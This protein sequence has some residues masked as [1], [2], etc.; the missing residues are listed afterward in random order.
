[1]QLEVMRKKLQRDNDLEK[2]KN[3]LADIRER[4]WH[5]DYSIKTLREVVSTTS[6]T[7]ADIGTDEEDIFGFERE[8]CRDTARRFLDKGK[9]SPDNLNMVRSYLK[10]GK[11]TM[12]DIS[13]KAFNVRTLKRIIKMARKQPFA[14]YLSAI[15]YGLKEFNLELADIGIS[16]KEIEQLFSAT[17]SPAPS[18]TN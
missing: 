4:E 12:D 2:A 11:L 6:I 15:R 17:I 5:A 1:M 13:D 8:A 16:E 14:D 18:T 7:F 3:L 10:K 9:E